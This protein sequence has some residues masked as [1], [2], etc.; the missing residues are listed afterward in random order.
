MTFDKA[1]ATALF[2]ALTSHAKGL[3][4]FDRV[5]GHEPENTPGNGVSCSVTGTSIEAIPA[6]GLASV[7]GKITFTVRIWSPMNT[8]PLDAVD[9]GVIAAVSVLLNEYSGSFTLGG[10]VRNID[11]IGLK[12]VTAYIEQEGR[13]FRVAEITVPILVNDMWGEVA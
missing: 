2:S 10:T 12:A 5:N 1:A 11:L 7:S 6:S 4:V 13:E 8:R 9:P 3:A